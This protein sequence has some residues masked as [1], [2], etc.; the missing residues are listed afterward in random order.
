MGLGIDKHKLKIAKTINLFIYL[1]IW[2][3]AQVF[4]DILRTKAWGKI[5]PRSKI[6]TL[7]PKL[8]SQSQAINSHVLSVFSQN[9]F[10]FVIR[11]EKK[12]LDKSPIN[13]RFIQLSQI[14]K[15]I[16][17]VHINKFKSRV[18]HK[19][20]ILFDKGINVIQLSK[21]KSCITHNL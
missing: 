8:N 9:Y 1:S 13:I 10:P 2:L 3:V 11:K 20:Q 5:H 21:F 6:V 16:K 4:S 15:G 7:I 12:S 19:L 17:V 14:I 18:T